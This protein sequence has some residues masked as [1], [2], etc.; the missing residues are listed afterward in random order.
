MLIIMVKA[1]GIWC[2]MVAVAIFNAAIREKLLV[3]AVG[4]SP[5]LPL[6]GLLLTFFLFVLIYFTLPFLAG[7]QQWHYIGVGFFWFLL[8]LAFELLFGRYGAGKSWQELLEV[9]SVARGNLFVLAL[10]TTLAGPW[11]AARLRGLI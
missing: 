11:L 4:E 1:G 7:R 9:F 10:L 3:P 5:A 2:L 8:T 6:S